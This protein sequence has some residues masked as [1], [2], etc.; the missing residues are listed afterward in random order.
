M[1]IRLIDDY[2]CAVHLVGGD[3]S[4]AETESRDSKKSAREGQKRPLFPEP[5]LKARPV[6]I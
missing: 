3:V 1:R 6:Y 5:I 4:H 2:R